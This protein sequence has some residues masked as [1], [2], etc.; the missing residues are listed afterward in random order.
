VTIDRLYRPWSWR[1]NWLRATLETP[2]HSR[3]VDLQFIDA[4]PMTG[5]KKRI[6]PELAG[7]CQYVLRIP[8]GITGTA[9]INENH[10]KLCPEHDPHQA[11][12][13][14]MAERPMSMTA[15]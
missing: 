1:H 4:P 12:R 5:S 15:K 3:E 6:I 13:A 10:H 7:Q 14:C 11:G 9:A 8:S 2:C